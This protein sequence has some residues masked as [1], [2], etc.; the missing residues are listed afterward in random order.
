MSDPDEP[1]RGTLPTTSWSLI[2]S[3]ARG[4]DTRA[5]SAL[6]TLCQTYWYP[7]Y[8]YM[9]RQGHSTTE[10][11]DLTQGFFARLI[12]KRYL[13]DF[14]PSRGRFR[15][16][17]LAALRHFVANER[18]YAHAQRRGGGQPVLSLDF[19]DAERRFQFE[20]AIDLTP[21]RIYE[22][23]WA[24]AL[25]GRVVSRLRQEWE[26]SGRADQ[27]TAMKAFLTGDRADCSYRDAAD[28]IGT[29]ETALKVAV[30]R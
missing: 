26:H 6:A 19:G 2:L 12:E 16:F 5:K 1:S 3:A 14:V 13:G 28:K 4:S 23:D 11:E 20:P 10:A 29:S 27:F 25:L 24:L 15:T 30:H 22:R 17:L 18:D 8:A 7:L 9:R 21:E